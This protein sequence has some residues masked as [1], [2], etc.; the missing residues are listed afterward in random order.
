MIL[1][2]K[3]TPEADLINTWTQAVATQFSLNQDDLKNCYDSR[4]DTHNSEMRLRYMWKYA[5]AKQVTGTPVAFV[6][7]IM[8]NSFPETADEWLQ[9]VTDVH[10]S[11]YPKQEL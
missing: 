6:N 3:T 10:N 11:Q 4:K 8:I 1:G 7:G 9:L 5:A 2:A